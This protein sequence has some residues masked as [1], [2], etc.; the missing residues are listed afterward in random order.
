[1]LKD[2]AFTWNSHYLAKHLVYV[3][4]N[5]TDHLSEEVVRIIEGCLVSCVFRI[6]EVTLAGQL[7]RLNEVL[8]KRYGAWR[9]GVQHE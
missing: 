7:W 4:F 8:E 9:N 6:F 1:M 3:V 5:E 2:N